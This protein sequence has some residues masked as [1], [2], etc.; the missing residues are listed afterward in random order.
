M[1]PQILPNIVSYDVR[2]MFGGINWVNITYTDIIPLL[3]LEYA[4]VRSSENKHDNGKEYCL[5][6]QMIYIIFCRL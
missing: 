5:R 6:F 2:K 4:Y 1:S 3:L